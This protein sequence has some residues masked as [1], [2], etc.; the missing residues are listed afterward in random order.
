PAL[1]LGFES[2]QARPF[3]L[4]LM[5]DLCSV[6]R[7]EKVKFRADEEVMIGNPVTKAITYTPPVGADV[8]QAK[9]AN[10]EDFLL[11]TEG[12]LDPLVRMAVA[13]YE[14]HALPPSPHATGAA[15]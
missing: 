7:H 8:M 1:R 9:L 2:I 10:L 5:E 6:L 3:R 15:G 4:H 11:S 13:H 14:C 12:D